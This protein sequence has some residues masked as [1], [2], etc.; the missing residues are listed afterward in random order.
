MNNRIELAL[1]L[2]KK[3]LPF[4]AGDLRFELENYSKFVVIGWSQY[5]NFKSL[6]KASSKEELSQIKNIFLDMLEASQDLKTFITDTLIE[7]RLY[8][9]D[10]GKTSIHICSEQDKT[11]NWKVDIE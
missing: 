7:Y 1:D 11:I 2:L 5:L 8:F 10:G 6:T 9:D 3:G 4:S